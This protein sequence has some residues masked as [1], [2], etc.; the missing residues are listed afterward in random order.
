MKKTELTGLT[1][2]ELRDWTTGE[3]GMRPYRAGQLFTWVH[4]RRV[5]SFDDM[6]DISLDARAQ[7]D[8]RAKLTRLVTVN[9]LSAVDGTVKHCFVLDDD[10]HIES[11]LIPDEPRLTACLSTQV[12]CKCGCIFCQTGLAGFRRDLSAAEMVAQLYALQDFTDQRISNVVFMGMGE[13]LDNFR[14]LEDALSIISD[15]RGICIGARKITV[16]TIGLPGGIARLAG[17]EGQ[18]GLAVSLHSAVPATRRKLVPASR[19]LS[20]KEL[21]HD[22]LLYNEMTGRRVTLEYCLISGLNDSISE[23]AALAGFCADIQCKINLLV[24]NPVKGM[25]LHRPGPAEV[26]KFMEYLYPRCQA[27]TLRRSRGSDI[28]AACGQL[29]ASRMLPNR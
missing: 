20:L 19:A 27:V 29:G 5:G 7:L 6:T 28:A 21:K 1:F 11:V 16:S 3:M 4:R 13:P 25:D 10:E 2:R 9:T 26:E 24:Y 14:N 17:L 22:L 15:D 18:Y 12:G 23:A 8:G